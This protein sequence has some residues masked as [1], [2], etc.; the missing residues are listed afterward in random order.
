MFLFIIPIQNPFYLLNP[1]TPKPIA[2]SPTKSPNPTISHRQIRHPSP[3]TVKKL[4]LLAQ[5]CVPPASYPPC[6]HC[7]HRQV[8][9]SLIHFHSFSLSCPPISIINQKR[10]NSKSL[11]CSNSK[12]DSDEELELCNFILIY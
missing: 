3:V 10:G 11:I 8:S 12:N 4:P 9:C 1:K 5:H 6:C 7:H 2:L